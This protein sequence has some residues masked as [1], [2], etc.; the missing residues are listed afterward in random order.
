MNN[1]D[2]LKHFIKRLQEV[3]FWNLMR[4]P[5][6]KA[7]EHYRKAL[8]WEDFHYKW[9]DSE[10]LLLFKESAHP[11][12]FIPSDINNN[13]NLFNEILTTGHVNKHEF[14]Q[15]IGT[16]ILNELYE[17]ELIVDDAEK[18]L[19]KF[20]IIP[21]PYGAIF[22]DTFSQTSYENI[23]IGLDSILFWNF[24][25][26]NRK[27]LRNVKYALDLGCG[28]GIHSL[29][30][31]NINPDMNI[32]C[33]DISEKCIIFTKT[34]MSNNN[35]ID[36]ISYIQSDWFEK[37]RSFPQANYDLIICN[38][39]FEWRVDEENNYKTLSSYG[40]NNYGI[41]STLTVLKDIF[42]IDT[43]FKRR[44]TNNQI[45]ICLWK[46]SNFFKPVTLYI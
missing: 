39:P 16:D 9:F 20:R 30:L 43:P 45:V 37:V 13:Y 10:S 27:N 4:I 12:K 31:K 22:A 32:I 21:T 28:T 11:E 18:I 36:G 8:I 33:S 23:H 6:Y 15:I 5:T 2:A 42:F 26:K 44:I 19:I 1:I 29:L 25:N 14:E 40:G 41:E 38:P 34:N 46:T 3:G 7:L 24:L 35:I 17:S